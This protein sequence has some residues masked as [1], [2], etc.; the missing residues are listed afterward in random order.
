M[1]SIALIAFGVM[2]GLLSGLLGIGGGIILVP[3][4]IMLFGFTQPEAQGTSLAVLSIPILIFAASVY[5]QN[6]FV[7]L[8]VVAYIAVGVV[9]GAFVGAKFAGHVPTHVLRA[10]FGTLLLYVGFLFV[11]DRHGSHASVALPSAL[12]TI[13]TAL[14]ARVF[15]WRLKRTSPPEPPSAEREYYI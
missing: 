8:P 9:L 3:G 10:F 7:R 2:V 1:S 15:H 13:L 12:A 11:L 4:L 5:Y 6:G 14:L